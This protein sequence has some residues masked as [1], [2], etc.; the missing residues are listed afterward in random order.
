MGPHGLPLFGS[1]DW[2]D[3]MNRVGAAGAGR[4]HVARVLPPFGPDGVR[5]D[6]RPPGRSRAR[7]SVSQRGAC[8]WPARSSAPGTA[9]GTGAATT[10][11]ARRSARRRTTSAGS[12]RSRSRGRCS[13]AP[14]RTSSP[15]GRWTA[16]ARSCWLARR[17]GPAAAASAVRPSAQDP[18]LHQGLSAGRARERRSVHARGRL[19]RDGAGAAG[20]RRRSRRGVPHAESR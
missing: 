10:T 15:T 18:G 8:A 14:C 17:A 4:E 16:C 12:I 9:S 7:R 1:G 20:Q 19:D 5:A 13:R 11:T 2:N 3:G 6:L